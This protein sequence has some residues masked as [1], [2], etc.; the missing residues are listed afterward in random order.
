MWIFKI[1][2]L[3]VAATATVASKKINFYI[4]LHFFILKKRKK[5]MRKALEI[6]LC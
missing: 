5:I 4:F 1:H 3:E 2:Q 6:L